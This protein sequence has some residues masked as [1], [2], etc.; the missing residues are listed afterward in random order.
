MEDSESY[1][2]SIIIPCYN[3]GH[4][5]PESIG[6]VLGQSHK[7][8]EIIVVND[9]STD[10]TAEVCAKY[11]SR[12]KHV[13]K[14]NAGLSA[15]RNTGITH[16]IGEFVIFLDADDCLY[17]DAIIDNMKYLLANPNAAFVSGGFDR[18]R[19]EDNLVEER[20]RS[21]EGNHYLE[22]LQGNY[23]GVPAAVMYRR[24][25]LDEFVF[26][27]EVPNSCSDYDHY[28]RIGRKYPLVH[29]TKKITAYRI[30]SSSMSADSSM[31]LR[32]VLKVHSRQKKHL[33]T[34]EEENAYHFGI[35]IW[36]GYYSREIYLKLKNKEVVPTQRTVLT[37]L[38][39]NYRLFFKFLVLKAVGSRLFK[40]IRKV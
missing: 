40:S 9:G 17:P 11:D 37:L 5:L 18:V 30:H 6:S 1:L 14:K 2:V 32:D 23:I 39:S 10:K 15:A 22:L 24:W 28:L 21:V 12:V 38:Q 27:L 25:V 4:F 19:V 3:H 16:C 33:R 35:K 31:M 13:Y 34:K 29:H 26:D 20:V 8:V 7:N 36:K